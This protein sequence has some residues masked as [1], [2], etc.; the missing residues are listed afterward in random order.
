MTCKNL[1]SP[2]PELKIPL[3]GAPKQELPQQPGPFDFSAWIH[4]QEQRDEQRDYLMMD[5]HAAI[6]RSNQR[7]YHHIYDALLVSLTP[8]QFLQSC[9]WPRDRTIYSGGGGTYGGTNDDEE[10]TTSVDDVMDD[11]ADH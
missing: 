8:D 10:R 1:T 3:E 4:Q 6:F 5:Q 7:I 9:M 11:D 2:N